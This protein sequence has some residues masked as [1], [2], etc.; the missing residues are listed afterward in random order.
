MVIALIIILT[1]SVSATLS[2]IVARTE[3]IFNTFVPFRSLMGDLVIQKDVEHPLGENYKI[4]DAMDF[5]FEVELGAFYANSLIETTQGTIRAD[6]NGVLSGLRVKPGT[7]FYIKGIDEATEVTIREILTDA[8]G[9][10]LRPGFTAKESEQTLRISSGSN[11]ATAAFT[12]IYTPA[13]AASNVEVLLTKKLTGRD[14]LADDVFYFRLEAYNEADRLWVELA[15]DIKVT[16]ADTDH[17]VD[18][19]AYLP[20]VYNSVGTYAYRLT[21]M[22]GKI[23]GMTYDVLPRYFYITIVDRTMD[24]VLDVDGI[25]AEGN[26]TTNYDEDANLY[27]VNAVFTNTGRDIPVL[28][29]DD[30]FGYIVGYPEDYRTG[31]PTEDKTL[32]PVR[33]E[34]NITRAEVASIFYRLLTDA[35]RDRFYCRTNPYPDVN[36]GNWFNTAIS[37]LTNAGVLCGRTDGTFDPNGYITRAELSTIAA[38]F[39]DASYSGADYFPDIDG[40]WAREYINSAA[41]IGLIFGYPDGTFRPNNNITRAETVSIINRTLGRAPH[42]DHLHKDMDVWPDN[43]DTSKWYYADMQEATNSHICEFVGEGA[44]A[45][46][47]WIE[48]IPMRDWIEL[49]K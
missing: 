31:E 43:M 10:D 16:A 33:P 8:D 4:P 38:R 11:I 3:T 25:R 20:D 7:D 24:G 23:D 45:Y 40:H 2:F 37:T 6:E 9:R 47:V 41:S 30:H 17:T 32:W 19:T 27:T 28:N 29:R 39:Y 44:D 46:E 14:W 22:E 35:S 49:E 21:E 26:C 15:D 1:V 34:G 5:E 13:A 18:I 12:N 36:E 42:K 48:I